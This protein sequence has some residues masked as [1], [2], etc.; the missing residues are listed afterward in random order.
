LLN[1]GALF[2]IATTFVV[3]LQDANP[4]YKVPVHIQENS[5][6]SHFINVIRWLKNKK[7]N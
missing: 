4:L 6:S 7:T 3:H 1:A 5:C 2:Y